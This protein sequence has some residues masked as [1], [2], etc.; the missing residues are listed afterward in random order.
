MR[1]LSE[2]AKASAATALA[3][4]LSFVP[5]H[6][7]ANWGATREETEANYK[8]DALMPNAHLRY[9]RAITIDAPAEEV[10]PW[11]AQIGRG[12]GYYSYD[13]LDNG[14]KPSADHLLDLPPPA[15]GDRNEAIGTVAHVEPGREIV[16]HV[17]GVPFFGADAE[18]V[19]DYTVSPR[20]MHGS[21]TVALILGSVR[22]RTAWPA[23][24][25]FEIMDYVMASEQLRGLKRR[26]ETYAARQRRRPSAP[27]AGAAEHQRDGITYA[28]RREAQPS[29]G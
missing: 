29:G 23:R 18:L 20:A 12:A 2:L 22:G 21:R 7:L 3:V 10:W 24:R 6:R 9:V 8:G 25:V 27:C 5:G 17:N 14:G 4:L 19:I 28:G 15:Q 11:V 26:V 16:W 13:M 1:S